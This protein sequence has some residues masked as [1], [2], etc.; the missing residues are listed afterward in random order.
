MHLL[1]DISIFLYGIG[2]RIASL[3]NAKAKAW[4]KGRKNAFRNLPRT[5]QQ[6]IWFHCASLGEFDQGLPLMFKLKQECPDKYL[7]VTFFS[8]SGMQFK[9]KRNHPVDQFMYL[10]LDTRSNAKK[11]IAHFKPQMAFFVKYEF[12]SNVILQAK[13]EGCKLYNVSGIF[14][15]D[16]RFFK[17]YGGF[18]RKTL[19]QFSW[20]FVQN[21]ASKELLGTIGITNVTVTGDSRFDR[22]LENKKNAQPNDLIAAFKGIDELL[23]MGSSWPQDEELLAPFINTGSHK[24]LIAPHNVDEGHIKS[25]M[26]LVPDAIRYT[27]ATVDSVKDKKIMILDTMGQLSNAYQ[28]GNYAYIGGGFSGNLHNIL[29]PAVFNMPVF[30]GP[31]HTKFPEAQQFID[32]GFG[33]SISTLTEFENAFKKV[34]NEKAAI[35]QKLA[36]YMQQNAGSTEK[37][38]QHFTSSSAL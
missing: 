37:I 11:F 23:I 24:I 12:W 28:Y 20:F 27:K 34:A 33:F 9:D 26:K 8:P 3:F 10:P 13:Q 29:E 22:V 18:F 30:F 35:A 6:V 15:P 16:H 4:V 7:L 14:R 32:V 2:I 19:K 5:D 36:D 21:E 17:G 31:K 1:Y 25:I 38:W